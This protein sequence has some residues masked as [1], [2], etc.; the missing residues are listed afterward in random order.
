MHQTQKCASDPRVW[1]FLRCLCQGYLWSFWFIFL[2]W[3]HVVGNFVKPSQSTW[4]ISQTS[5]IIL[6]NVP[7]YIIHS[8]IQGFQYRLVFVSFLPSSECSNCALLHNDKLFSCL[9]TRRPADLSPSNSIFL[10]VRLFHSYRHQRLLFIWES[11]PC[12]QFDLLTI[13]RVN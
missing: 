11:Q 10:A 6:K 12:P 5:V 3:I 2:G 13:S 4:C 9:C 7:S 1:L 8:A